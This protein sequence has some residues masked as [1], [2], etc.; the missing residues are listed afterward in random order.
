[1][2]K[3]TNLNTADRAR[4]RLLWIVIFV[5][6]LTSC[7]VM[8]AGVADSAFPIA[9]PKKVEKLGE[10]YGTSI[11]VSLFHLFTIG[12]PD[13]AQAIRE[14]IERRGGTNLIGVRAYVQSIN[15]LL[16]TLH[17]LVVEGEV[18]KEEG[19]VIPKDEM[20]EEGGK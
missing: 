10:S 17:T 16:F 6:V 19:S 18:V 11:Y 15:M 2:N 9:N 8:P 20:F 5:G 3:Q 14:A 13:Y 12:K 4:G 1:M 7:S